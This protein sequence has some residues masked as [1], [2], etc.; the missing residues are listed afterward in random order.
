[1][2]KLSIYQ[3]IRQTTH[4]LTNLPAYPLSGFHHRQTYVIFSKQTSSYEKNV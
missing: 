4:Q 3:F 2:E 1:M